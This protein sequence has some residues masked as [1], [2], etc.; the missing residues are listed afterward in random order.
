MVMVNKKD[1]ISITQGKKHASPVPRQLPQDARI[2]KKTAE[3]NAM[4]ENA[5]FLTSGK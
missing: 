4:F 5:I 2:A 3:I 1:K